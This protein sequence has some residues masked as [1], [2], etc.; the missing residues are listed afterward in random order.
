MKATLRIQGKIMKRL[1]KEAAGQGK[2]V[3]E[4]AESAILLYL[5]RQQAARKLPPMPTFDGGRPLVDVADRDSLYRA[6]EG[7]RRG[8]R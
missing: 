5:E 4:L 2:T 1:E 8:R 6:M 7:R 3:S